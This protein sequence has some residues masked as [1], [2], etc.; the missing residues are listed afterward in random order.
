MYLKTAAL[1]YRPNLPF[2]QGQ[3]LTEATQGRMLPL[4]ALSSDSPLGRQPSSRASA[5][6]DCSACGTK[7]ALAAHDS[8]P[9]PIFW[10]INSPVAKQNIISVKKHKYYAWSNHKLAKMKTSLFGSFL[11]RAFSRNLLFLH[12]F[13]DSDQEAS[14]HILPE[15]T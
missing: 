9:P 14:F 10:S 6:W 13:G 15:R 8:L 5:H 4:N 12:L 7:V 11:S 2:G 3:S 1:Y